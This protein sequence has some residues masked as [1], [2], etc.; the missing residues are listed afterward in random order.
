MWLR[1]ADRLPDSDVLH[2]CV[3]AY[4][5]DLTLLHAGLVP[6]KVDIERTVR[7]SI[8][9]AMW[10]HRPFRADEWLLY[11]QVSPFAG[12]GRGLSIGRLFDVNGVLVAT[13][14]QE[15][16]IRDLRISGPPPA[17]VRDGG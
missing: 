16:L 11:D 7:A 3:L 14:M 17:P 4:M 13:A 5:S 10:F 1:A 12:G 2:R 8:D 6:H 9:H 15:G